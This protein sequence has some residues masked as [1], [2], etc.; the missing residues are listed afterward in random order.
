MID[1]TTLNMPRTIE[2]IINNNVIDKTDPNVIAYCEQIDSIIGVNRP[3]QIGALYHGL[4][5]F[6][7]LRLASYTDIVA[8][9]HSI[10]YGIIMFSPKE[11]QRE[12]KAILLNDDI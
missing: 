2:L 7:A 6:K 9:I 5:K 8:A 3:L 1:I 10:S 12:V 11:E 4:S